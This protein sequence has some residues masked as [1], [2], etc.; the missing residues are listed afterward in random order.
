MWSEIVDFVM[1]MLM[2][3]VSLSFGQ[4]LFSFLKYIASVYSTWTLKDGPK[5]DAYNIGENPQ[6]R[7][8]IRARRASPVWILL[9]RH[10]TDKVRY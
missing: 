8:E 5:K 9:T 3:G 1:E 6:Y 10:I 7:L 4:F 2:S